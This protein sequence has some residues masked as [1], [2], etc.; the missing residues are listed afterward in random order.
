MHMPKSLVGPIKARSGSLH[1][2]S[3]REVFVLPSCCVF[4]NRI[5]IISLLV[6]L[7]SG[8]VSCF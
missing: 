7:L 3:V 4:L 8:T 6:S 5:L 1:H 2:V